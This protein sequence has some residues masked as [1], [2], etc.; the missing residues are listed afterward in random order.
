MN[1]IVPRT[2]GRQQFF[3]RLSLFSTQTLAHAR[4]LYIYIYIYMLENYIAVSINLCIIGK[5]KRKT[6][7]L[8]F[9]YLFIQRL[10]S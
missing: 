3:L 6:F 10:V 7:Y 4:R 2:F 9:I 5:I 8:L 1:H